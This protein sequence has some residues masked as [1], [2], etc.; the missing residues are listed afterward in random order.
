MASTGSAW[1]NG[2]GGWESSACARQSR[3]AIAEQMGRTFR[4]EC[5]DQTVVRS[6]SQLQAILSQFVA[7]YNHDR[8]HRS[9]GLTTPDVI[10]R[11]NAGTLRCRP[12]LGGLHHSYQWAARQK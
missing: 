1:G 6:E 2:A 8:P 10:L 9:L 3:R 5:L 11:A 7:S 12:I 4:R